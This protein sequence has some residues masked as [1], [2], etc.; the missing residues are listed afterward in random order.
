LN[1]KHTYSLTFDF[2]FFGSF[3]RDSGETRYVFLEG[4]LVIVIGIKDSKYAIQQ[5]GVLEQH[6]SLELPVR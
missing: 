3:A 1:K 5:S 2:I 4:Y 6:G